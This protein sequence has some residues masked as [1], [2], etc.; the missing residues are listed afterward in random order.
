MSKSSSVVTG[1]EEFTYLEDVQTV[2]KSSPAPAEVAEEKG[3]AVSVSASEVKVEN[4]AAGSNTLKRQRTLMEM[5][6]SGSKSAD[7]D[8]ANK[9]AK[10]LVKE[11]VTITSGTAVLSSP[12]K[13]SQSGK[14]SLNSIAFSMAAFLESLDD[15]E[16]KLL[17]LECETMGKSW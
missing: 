8:Q 16:K 10:V 17:A 6:S 2:S 11:K 1:R 14:E 12:P 15:E 9:K 13:P 7:S 3:T 4:R 5:M